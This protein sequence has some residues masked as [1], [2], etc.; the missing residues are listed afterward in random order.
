MCVKV[1]YKCSVEKRLDDFHPSPSTKDKRMKMC[2]DCHRCSKTSVKDRQRS[3][4]NQRLIKSYGISI[5]RYEEMEKAQNGLCAICKSPRKEGIRFNIDHNH[6][7]GQV[8]GL[9]CSGC[10]RGLGY[11]KDRPDL[12]KKAAD[13]LISNDNLFRSNK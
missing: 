3:F 12:I 4:E 13:Y 9:L 5:E 11:F 1:C 7:T 2:K 8:R 6:D 10:N